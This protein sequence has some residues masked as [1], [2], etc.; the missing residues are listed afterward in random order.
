MENLKKA[1]FSL[2]TYKITKAN[3]DFAKQ[4]LTD[5]IGLILD[6]SGEFKKSESIFD[7][8]II[9]KAG[10]SNMESV[11]VECEMHGWFKFSNVDAQEDIPDYFFRN[12]I[13]IIFP[14]LR[15]FISTL[16]LQAN[17]KN[18]ILPTM[19]LSNLESVLKSNVTE[20]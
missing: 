4:E 14:Y 3:I 12:S 2:S 17:T 6:P 7:L 1:A 5:E 13:A 8:K 19:N 18:L 11:L 20:V 9:F 16:T 10:T 15:S